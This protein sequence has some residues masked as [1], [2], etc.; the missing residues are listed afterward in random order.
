MP[1]IKKVKIVPYSQDDMFALVN[2]VALYSDFIP[3]CVSSQMLSRG[4]DE[5]RAKLCFSKGGISKSFTTLNRLKTNKMIEIRLVDGPFKHL[6][7]FWQFQALSEKRCKISLDLEF[8]FSSKLLGMMFG[9]LFHQVASTLVDSFS[10]RA[11][12]IYGG[13]E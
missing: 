8:E 5:L 2:D 12:K 11:K 9:P 13:N 6:E 4:V 7:G 3:W 1:I 10:K